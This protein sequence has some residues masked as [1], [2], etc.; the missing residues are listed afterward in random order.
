ME[1]TASERSAFAYTMNTIYLWWQS[2]DVCDVQF[3]QFDV[4]KEADS[5]GDFLIHVLIKQG[6]FLTVIL[7]SYCVIVLACY[8]QSFEIVQY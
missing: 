5:T 8:C 3:V 6:E 1:M 2:Y 7:L 4:N